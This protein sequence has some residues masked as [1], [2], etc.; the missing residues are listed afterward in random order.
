M[1]GY[2]DPNY[3]PPDFFKS[4]IGTSC[5][6]PKPRWFYN[7]GTFCADVTV[8][9]NLYVEGVTTTERLIVTEDAIINSTLGVAG[10]STLSE[11]I[12]AGSASVGSSLS[13]GGTTSTG[14]IVVGGVPYVPTEITV[15]EG[16]FTVLAAQ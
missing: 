12:V 8:T 3:S 14:G 11:V 4:D 1:S 16:T 7:G 5:S 6:K 9:A 13:V 2:P 10:L 15:P